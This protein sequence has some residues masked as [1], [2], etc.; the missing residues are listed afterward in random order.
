MKWVL[1]VSMIAITMG[2]AL[3]TAPAA[4]ASV[5]DMSLK[6]L[7]PDTLAVAFVDVAAL[8][9]SPLVQDVLK[10]K[11]LPIPRDMDEFMKA[12]GFDPQRDIDKITFAKVSAQEE[13]IVAQARVDRFKAEQF[14]K[15][16]GKETEVYLGQTLYRGGRN[17][18][19]LLDG[20]VLTGRVNTVKKAIDQMQLPGSLPLRSEL[21]AAM[22][23]IDA[24]SHVWAVGQ[25]STT[26]LGK[27]G[28]RG[29]APAMDMIQSLKAGTYQM[30]VDTGIHARATGTFADAESAKDTSDL[31]RGALAVAKLQVA[32]QNPDMLPL[33]NG[34][35]VSNSGTTVTV[36]IEEPAALLEKLKDLKLGG[37]KGE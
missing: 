22:Q 36:L 3:V 13:L 10:E 15:E 2:L 27:L 28:V 20:V 31:A 14:L 25:I 18:L 6:F 16:K 11:G 8:R 29:P 33:L 34:I 7:P 30:R 21:T 17:A 24:G 23:T 35:Q 26:D 5:D 32:K 19:L 37:G 1:G 4:T 9:N 12:T